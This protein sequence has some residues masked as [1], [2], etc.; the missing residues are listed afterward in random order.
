MTSFVPT[1]GS[2]E[3]G[4]FDVRGG[5]FG[6]GGD[7][8]SK[9]LAPIVRGDDT[10]RPD[11]VPAAAGLLAASPGLSRMYADDMEQ[12]EAGILLYDAVYRWR[13][14]ATDVTHKR[15]SHQPAKGRAT[16][17]V[18]TWNERGR[19]CADRLKKPVQHK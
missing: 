4:A 5:A 18:R 11:L 13:R 10:G 8:P 16:A 3:R 9:R 2:S 19:D 14:D 7:E 17:T 15:V 6:R 12:L 1:R